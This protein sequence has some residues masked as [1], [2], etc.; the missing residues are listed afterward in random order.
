MFLSPAKINL[1]LKVLYKRSDGY[2]E[3]DSIFLRLNWGDEISF[4]PLPEVKFVLHSEVNLDPRSKK[5]YLSVS[6]HGNIEKNILYK[7]WLKALDLGCKKGVKILLKKKIPTGAGLGGG[8]SNS[9]ELFRFLF[10]NEIGS[11]SFLK[12]LSEVGA[13][14]PFF[15]KQRHQRVRGIGEILEDIFIPRG[16]GVLALTGYIISTK[17]AFLSLKK[18]LHPPPP[19]ELWIKRKETK[20]F[21]ST[22][23][24]FRDFFLDLK[25]DFEPYVLE[26]YPELKVLRD[27]ME[28]LGFDY[29]SMTGTGSSF[30]GLT[31]QQ[32]LAQDSVGK[33]SKKFPHHRFEIFRF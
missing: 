33:L 18:T 2:H 29:V 3:I 17:D 6:E 32:E 8:S 4:E 27:Y 9:A 12:E 28:E 14:V 10:P 15:W 13:D 7:T 21:F 11:N 16:W 5:D 22:W 20:N 1:G 26:L 31:S 30:Y 24:E 23:E 19:T 25:N